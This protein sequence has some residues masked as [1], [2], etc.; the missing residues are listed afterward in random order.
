[1]MDASSKAFLTEGIATTRDTTLPGRSCYVVT[2]IV[3]ES[4]AILNFSSK[5]LTCDKVSGVPRCTTNRSRVVLYIGEE[6]RILPSCFVF[7]NHN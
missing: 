1:M 4:A 7:Q 6:A 3:A 2:S 5:R